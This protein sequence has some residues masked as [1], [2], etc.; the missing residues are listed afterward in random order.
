MWY[1]FIYD[2]FNDTV[3]NLYSV[4]FTDRVV[5]NNKLERCG[6]NWLWPNF[7]VLSCNFHVRA[8]ENHEIS[9]SN[10]CPEW[11]LNQAFLKYKSEELL[12]EPTCFFT[13]WYYRT[14]VRCSKC[15]KL[16]KTLGLNF[17]TIWFFACFD[18]AFY[19]GSTGMCR[20]ISSWTLNSRE[21]FEHEYC[22]K[23]FSGGGSI[24]K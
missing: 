14:L 8:E 11:D 9:Q 24:R 23:C 19:W 3:S 1:I 17:R 21:M 20:S 18:I 2:L 7:V 13:V 22:I 5:F 6:R 4:M 16:G 12:P 10:Q 15:L